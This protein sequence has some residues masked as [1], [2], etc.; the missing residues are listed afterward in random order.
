MLY[1][2]YT[3]WET[4]T[5]ALPSCHSPSLLLNKT[6]SRIRLLDL[7]PCLVFTLTNAMSRVSFF[8]FPWHIWCPW[9]LSL[10]SQDKCDIRTIYSMYM[11]LPWQIWCSRHLPSRYLDKCDV[12][13][14]CLVFTLTNV[15]SRASVSSLLWQMWCPGHLS[16]LYLDKCDDQGICLVFTL[17]NVM[18]R[19]SVSSL[20]WQMWCPGHLSRLYLDKCDVQSICLVVNLFEADKNLVTLRT[21]VLV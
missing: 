3:T 5:K 7:I 17:T 4:R 16:R 8:P 9:H 10:L 12:Q 21:V 19:A 6:T 1:K 15:M 18:S 20:P 13:S 14:I 2:Q 11:S